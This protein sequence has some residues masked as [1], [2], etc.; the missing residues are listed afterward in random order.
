MLYYRYV[1]TRW[2]EKLVPIR[3]LTTIIMPHRD[4]IAGL[5][6]RTDISTSSATKDVAPVVS[7]FR[8]MSS[9]AAL[10]YGIANK[11][12]RSKGWLH[13]L[14]LK[15]GTTLIHIDYLVK[16]MTCGFVIP[17]RYFG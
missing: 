4:K 12:Y 16:M 1:L 6:P 10:K 17:V 15:E 9:I 5:R 8:T 14:L 13:R 2:V 11:L 7:E 3:R